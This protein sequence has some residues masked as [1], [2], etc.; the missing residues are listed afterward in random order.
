[1]TFSDGKPR[2]ARDPG[3]LEAAEDKRVI[4]DLASVTGYLSLVRGKLPTTLAPGFAARLD[5]TQMATLFGAHD[6]VKFDSGSLVL[7]GRDLKHSEQAL[8]ECGTPVRIDRDGATFAVELKG[9]CSVR[10]SD[11]RPMEIRL[12]G[13]LRAEAGAAFTSAS[14]LTGTLEANVTHSYSSGAP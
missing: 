10:A 7:R 9:T 12:S 13:P 14:S 4:F 2:V 5:G 1:V 3:T 6:S 8:F 11:S